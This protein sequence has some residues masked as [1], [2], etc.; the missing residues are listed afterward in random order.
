M[1]QDDV[2]RIMGAFAIGLA[3]GC[4]AR[5][6]GGDVAKRVATKQRGEDTRPFPGVC[7]RRTGWSHSENHAATTQVGYTRHRARC[8]FDNTIE[9]ETHLEEEVGA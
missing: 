7:T 5:G 6:V 2:A 3:R 8:G 1:H 9:L 4:A